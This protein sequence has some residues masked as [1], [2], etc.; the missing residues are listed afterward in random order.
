MEDS[1]NDAAREAAAR[2]ALQP[3]V[4]EY[5]GQLFALGV[6]FCGNR[7][8]A[9]DLVQEV[10]LQA[11]RG[12]HTFEGRSSPKTWLYTIAARACQRMHRKRAGQPESVP[13]LDAPLPF[14]EPM[15]AVIPSEQDDPLQEQIRREARER[16]E[17]EIA[18]LP[19]AFRVPL[20]LKEIV[21][22]TVPEVAAILGLEQGTIKSRVHRA[23]LRLRC[24][25]DS[26]LPRQPDPAPPP[27]YS[28]QTCLDLLNAK[29]E[30]LDRGVDFDAE[31]ICARC[32]SV[33]AALDLSQDVCRQLG[34]GEVPDTLRQRLQQVIKSG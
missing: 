18:Q 4:D 33:F 6:R 5:A 26:V 22:M 29:Q 21:G 19:E 32:R 11:F 30:A 12:W 34:R 25:V 27:A 8:E 1:T 15:I 3:L 2:A 17:S 9:E 10:F 14:G 7:S 16:I 31:V 20:I 24:A 28:Q 13:S 23:R